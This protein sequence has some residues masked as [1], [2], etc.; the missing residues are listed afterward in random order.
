MRLHTVF[1]MTALSRRIQIGHKGVIYLLL[2]IVYLLFRVNI[3]PPKN[4][5]GLS[6][7]LGLA[8]FSFQI[9]GWGGMV[10]PP[11]GVGTKGWG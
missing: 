3:K 7:C 9:F 8:G 5:F 1:H 2:F 10:P 6:L 11:L 4:R